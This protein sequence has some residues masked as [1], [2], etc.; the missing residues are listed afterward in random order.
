MLYRS[1]DSGTSYIIRETSTVN[2]TYGFATDVLADGVTPAWDDTNTVNIGLATGQLTSEAEL[3]V[4]NGANAA[5][6]GAHGRWEIIQFQTATLEGDGTYTLSTLLRGRRGTE[7]NTANHLAGDT[8]VLLTEASLTRLNDVAADISAT[9]L[10]KSVSIGNTLQETTG[11][12]F[13][14]E[15]VSITPFSPTHIAGTRDGSNNLTVTFHRRDYMGYRANYT[16]PM[17]EDTE[18]YELEY[19][20]TGLTVQYGGTKTASSETHSYTAA[21]QTTDGATPGQAFIVKIFQISAIIGR[22][23]EGQAT[24]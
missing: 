20:N 12:P 1:Q 3:S 8:F 2:A 11:L 13:T 22:G 21:Q 18:S 9:Y 10:Y 5:A 15:G 14:S 4:L 23:Y 16:L 19:W 17:S 6:F 7:H 24:V